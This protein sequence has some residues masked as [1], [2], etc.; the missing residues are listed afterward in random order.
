VDQIA[1]NWDAGR[2]ILTVAELTAA[3]GD[4]LDRQFGL[5]WVA[6]E[7]SGC[8]VPSSGHYYFTL[9]D[10]DAQLS[11]VCYKGTARFLKFK[12]RDGVAVIARGR[13]DVWPPQGKYQMVVEALE[14]QGYGA[15]QFEFEQLKKKLAM[16]G[17]FDA[18]RKRPLPKLPLRIGLVTSPSGAVIQD[19]L[20]ILSRRFP[21]LHIRLYPAL[22]QGEGSVEAVCR[23][24]QYFSQSGW[25][26]VV[27]LARGGGS[28]EDLWTFNDE[29]V[30]R[31]IA[32][33]Q[34]P[35]ISA[36]GHETDFT[37]ADFVADLRAPTPSA[38]AELVICTREQ[39]LEQIAGCGGRLEKAMHFRVMQAGR[40]LHQ[41]G[42]DR[43]N[44][45]LHRALARLAQR[46][47]EYEYT[48]RDRLRIAMETAK[49]RLRE[50]E[51]RRAQRDIRIVV[52]QL[53]QRIT[54]AGYRLPERTRAGLQSL[55]RR[56]TALDGRL[57][58]FDPKLVLARKRQ[59]LDAVEHALQTAIAARQREFQRAD[60]RIERA[61]TAL[62]EQMNRRM[63]LALNQVGLAAAKLDQLGPRKV[64]ERG[65]AIVQT[66]D[67]AVVK[68]ADDALPG[69][70]LRISVA[71]GRFSARV[72]PDG[73][74]E[75]PS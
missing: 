49:R 73:S 36:I 71:K 3:I 65:Y 34:V 47:D 35:V 75:L 31:A 20:N 26:N 66:M 25:A 74:S 64:L 1:L 22:V 57:R 7:I 37:I 42:V 58:Q 6:G 10:K 55:S 29:R 48:L 40:A 43:A 60:H 61:R 68:A 56:R 19:M 16:E 9:K 39:L 28:L 8:R 15:L 5:C 63:G 72:T 45:V 59:R 44:A 69:S 52:A 14:P 30:A 67:G 50:L 70:E 51:G 13:L 4:L 18:A 38:A 23:G 41:L 27:I 24:L 53:R 32:A 46:L 2:R 54:N 21:G 62:V 33:S 11:A 12:P 17:L